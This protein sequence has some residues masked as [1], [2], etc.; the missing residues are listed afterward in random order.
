MFDSKVKRCLY[1][2]AFLILLVGFAMGIAKVVVMMFDSAK[3]SG[4][5]P[6]PTAELSDTTEVVQDTT[7]VALDTLAVEQKT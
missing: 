4:Q 1:Y 3:E 6:V 5:S 2:I 7:V